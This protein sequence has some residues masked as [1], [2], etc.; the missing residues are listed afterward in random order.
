MDGNALS[1]TLRPRVSLCARTSRLPERFRYSPRTYQPLCERVGF[2]SA[3]IFGYHVPWNRAFTLDHK[4]KQLSTEAFEMIALSALVIF[5]GAAITRVGL[6]GQHLGRLRLVSFVRKYS[7]P[8]L[9]YHRCVTVGIG[10]G[11][12]ILGIAGVAIAVFGAG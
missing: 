6:I 9:W 1:K 5:L 12:I 4:M 8:P 10:I 7:E 2:Q 11:A 3:R